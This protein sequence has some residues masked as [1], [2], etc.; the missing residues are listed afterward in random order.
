M[1][2]LAIMLSNVPQTALF[3]LCFLL[4]L[5]V[6]L[7][8]FLLVCDDLYVASHCI[9]VFMFF[10]FFAAVTCSFVD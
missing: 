5:H 2:A 9:V 6:Y 4:V 7:A 1:P 8:V 3:L 10:L